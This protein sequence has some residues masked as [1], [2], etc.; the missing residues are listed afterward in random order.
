MAQAKAPM[1]RG[2]PL[3]VRERVAVAVAAVRKIVSRR[4]D[5]KHALTVMEWAEDRKVEEAAWREQSPRIRPWLRDHP[6]PYSRAAAG[7]AAADQ[8]LAL[9]RQVVA[10]AGLRGRIAREAEA[11]IMTTLAD[12]ARRNREAAAEGGRLG[13]AHRRRVTGPQP[14]SLLPLPAPVR[15][16]ALPRRR[17][18]DNHPWR[19]RGL[20][21]RPPPPPLRDAGADQDG[22]SDAELAALEK[23][24]PSDAELADLDRLTLPYA[25]DQDLDWDR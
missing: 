6:D 17:P 10:A 18:A 14:I 24:V 20:M 8:V 12:F 4:P 1:E 2:I 11:E 7:R 13:A 19:G 25:S 21:R 15:P 5:L 22:P 9:V 3:P 16:A 23:A